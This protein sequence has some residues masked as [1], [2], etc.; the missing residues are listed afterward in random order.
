MGGVVT[1]F[2]LSE[3]RSSSPHSAVPVGPR[4]ERVLELAYRARRA[5]L[6]EGA[7]GIG[8]SEVVRH[9]A[10]KLGIR[11]VVL[12]LS[13]L[14]P[15]DLLG[16]P[17]I[18]NG[19]T[20]FALP[21]VLPHEGAGILMLEELNRAERYI[22]QPALQLLT[23]RRLHEYELPEG[24]V[25]FA[26]INPE[27][28][29]YQVT[30]LDRAL[31]ARFLNLAVRAD[32][33][34]WLAWAQTKGI[35][36][37]VIALAQAHE[38]ILEDVP[39]R[40]WT[41]VSQLLF[42]LNDQE[43]ADGTLLRDAL[44]GYLAPTWVEALLASKDSWASRISFD[45]RALLADY[46]PGC[47]LAEEIR[48]Y[49]ENGQTDRLSEIVERLAPLLEGPE[50]GV[51]IAQKQ[52]ALG[53]FEALLADLPGDGRE[54]LQ[55]ALGGNATAT[56]LIDVTPADLLQNYVGSAAEKKLAAWRSD[57]MKQHRIALAV[58][59]LRVTIEQPA[60]LPDLKKSNVAR[61]CL[62]HL[63]SQLREKHAMPL[64]ETLRRVGITPVRPA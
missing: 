38:R 44:G 53:A 33:P 16:L 49:R 28:A 7:T 15:P 19:R 40:T 50:A 30:S 39:P 9:V 24:W 32:R 42:T 26:A 60:R 55:E 2:A 8:K 56:S 61:T 3:N 25:C 46:A 12:D 27:T 62:G 45:V 52:L 58:T 43:R 1:K 29:E 14:E 5:V 11:T 59:A 54:R 21:H 57:P 36:P 18:E 48:G 63:L 34:S 10:T 47:A 64:V 35:H 22:Q 31:R 37:G 4:L 6:L 17:I 23:A 51:L 13:L 41:Y 20:I